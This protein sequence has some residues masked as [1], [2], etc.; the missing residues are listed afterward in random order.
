[1]LCCCRLDRARMRYLITCVESLYWERSKQMVIRLC[2][3][4]RAFL[5]RLSIINLWWFDCDRLSAFYSWCFDCYPTMKIAKITLTPTTI[6]KHPPNTKR[7]NSFHWQFLS[8]HF[9]SSESTFGFRVLLCFHSLEHSPS[10]FLTSFMHDKSN[11]E[12]C[13]NFLHWDRK[14][15]LMPNTLSIVY[16]QLELMKF[17][18]LSWCVSLFFN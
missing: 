16:D 15:R 1:M 11:G 9:I 4:D 14:F 17:K 13:W 10:C 7:K 2:V 12:R 6:M 5:G 8:F 18:W 3:K